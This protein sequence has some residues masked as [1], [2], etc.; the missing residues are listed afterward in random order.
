MSAAA[1][2]RLCVL[3]PVWP[4]RD[5]DSGI[6]NI[7]DSEARALAARGHEVQ[8]LHLCDSVQAGVQA[9]VYDN[10]GL[11]VTEIPSGRSGPGTFFIG[12]L[13]A[14]WRA[15][16]ALRRIDGA[17]D[18]IL[19]TSYEFPALYYTLLRRRVPVLT[20]VSTTLETVD[21]L[22]GR[23]K[24]LRRAIPVWLERLAVRVSPLL[25]THTRAHVEFCAR[26]I[27]VPASRFILIPHGIESL[28]APEPET[29]TAPRTVLYVGRIGRRKGS[30]TLLAAAAAV[31]GKLP[32][33]RFELVGADCEH[34][35]A[36]FLAQHPEFADR[37]VL[38]GRLG[39]AERDAALAACYLFVSPSPYESFGMTYL[40]AMNRGKPV[41][42]CSGSGAAELIGDA[43]MAVPVGDA[44]ALAEVIG[45]LLADQDRRDRLAR[46][47][48]QRAREFSIGNTALKIEAAFR[49]KI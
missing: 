25:C 17:V 20:R 12:R 24:G 31:L 36:S 35:G 44:P 45:G 28:A 46:R 22:T 1:S 49:E 43:G 34:L 23:A 19:T 39:N 7:M 38:R 42:G 15:L 26:Q 10:R 5:A 27:G 13:L 4:A 6:A 3:T 2:L 21:E 9:R 8:V 16:A 14:P 18:G 48:A 33:C 37:L 41:I 40:E 29:W 11:Q 47:A 32:D 30:D